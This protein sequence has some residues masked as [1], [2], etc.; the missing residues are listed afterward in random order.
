MVASFTV[1]DAKVM[2][3]M[4]RAEIP[5]QVWFSTYAV[6]FLITFI[7]GSVETFAGVSWRRIEVGISPG[8]QLGAFRIHLHDDQIRT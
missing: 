1:A 8:K 5:A 4:S 2:V 3:T 6:L 7:S